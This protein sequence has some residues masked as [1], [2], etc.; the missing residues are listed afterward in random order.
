MLASTN[1]YRIT[2]GPE[3][4][5][6]LTLNG[7]TKE[8]TLEVKDRMTLLEAETGRTYTVKEINTD[9]DEMNS[10]LFRLGCYEGEP[11]TLV[12]KKKNSCI[13]VIKDGR[14]NLDA[15]LSEAIIV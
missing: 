2:G 9:D 8:E 7:I 13:V 10:F 6:E 5:A 14:Y 12:S 3:M 4:Q 1:R 11:I 15:L